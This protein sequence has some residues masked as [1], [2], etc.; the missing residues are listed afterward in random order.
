MLFTRK[1]QQR[2][3]CC[4]LLAILSF[5]K[6]T[7][8]GRFG[9]L[10]YRLWGTQLTSRR[11]PPTT[12]AASFVRTT[13]TTTT[14]TTTSKKTA[15][16]IPR[17][18]FNAVAT[19]TATATSAFLAFNGAFLV[20]NPNAVLKIIYKLEPPEPQDAALSSV[21]MRCIGCVSVGVAMT[22]YSSIVLQ[23]PLEWA[24]AIGLIPRLICF[25]GV[26]IF[27]NKRTALM[28]VNTILVCSCASS[29]LTGLPTASNTWKIFS[30]IG[31]RLISAINEM[32]FFL[33]HSVNLLPYIFY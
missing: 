29:L 2:L 9:S 22:V 30:S 31:T 33:T 5:S 17:G 19:T 14:T 18:G 10:T 13:T 21:L 3:F 28:V 24:V 6:G 1:N 8:G 25:A 15:L 27:Y 23:Q 20:A 16:V 7:F 26:L 11:T 12:T 4:F 32:S